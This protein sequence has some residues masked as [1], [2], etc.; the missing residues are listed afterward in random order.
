VCERYVGSR[1]DTSTTS[2]FPSGCFLCET[3]SC[4][5]NIIMMV[6]DHVI[7]M[8]KSRGFDPRI[9]QRVSA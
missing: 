6:D 2:L 1:S 4:G 3:R 9:E 5:D 7:D 8:R